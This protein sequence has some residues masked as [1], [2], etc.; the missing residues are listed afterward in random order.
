M[1]KVYIAQ[2]MRFVLW[3]EL[4]TG[5]TLESIH[6]LGERMGITFH[7]HLVKSSIVVVTGI[8]R[9]TYRRYAIDAISYD[10]IASDFWSAIQPMIYDMGYDGDYAMHFYDDTKRLVFI[11]APNRP[12]PAPAL[13][14]ARF[15]NAKLQHHYESTFLGAGTSIL[16]FTVFSENLSPLEEL[17]QVFM[18]L[19]Q[20]HSLNFFCPQ[21]RVMNASIRDSSKVN[22]TQSVMLQYVR[23][24][25]EAINDADKEKALSILSGQIYPSLQSS[26]NPTLCNRTVSAVLSQLIDINSVF[27]LQLERSIP[28]FEISSYTSIVA[29][30]DALAALV[31]QVVTAI[32]D[33]RHGY[34]TITRTAILYIQSKFTM[35]LDLS[36]IASYVSVAP[37]YLSRVFNSDVGMSLPNYLIYLRL[38]LA[39]KLLLETKL[40]I[41]QIAKSVGFSDN[42]YFGRVFKEQIGLSPN[43]FRLKELAQS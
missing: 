31:T 32:R 19:C 17:P 12:Q 5:Q 28:T 10:K 23:E 40:P 30:F 16:N 4:L 1:D 3:N 8:E 33:T 13:D 11:L 18:D 36:E 14:I 21:L 43:A 7:D 6:E 9:S 38:N 39:Q 29:L 27:E 22:C 42:S 24:L 35:P 41:K 26:L 2:L 15:I 25:S 37:A 20:L 34:S